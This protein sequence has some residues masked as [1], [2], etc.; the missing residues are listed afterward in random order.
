MLVR[1]TVTGLEQNWHF[2]PRSSLCS[3]LATT[4]VLAPAFSPRP[5]SGGEGGKKPLSLLELTD[6]V[7]ELGGLLVGL[8]ADRLQE[9]LAKLDQLGLHLA[10]LRQA[11]WGLAAV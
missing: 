11:P 1:C 7:T 4:L 6:A 8:L 2:T 9:L 10:G 3:A 5:R